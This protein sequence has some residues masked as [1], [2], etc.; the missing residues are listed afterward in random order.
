MSELSYLIWYIPLCITA[1]TVMEMCR[2]DS[3]QAIARKVGRNFLMLSG[4]FLGGSAL[5][6]VLQRML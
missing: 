4:L 1:L 6:L 3:P 5:V 2:E